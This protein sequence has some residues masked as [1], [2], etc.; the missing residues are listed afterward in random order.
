MPSGRYV[1]KGVN[2]VITPDTEIGDGTV[3]WHNVNLWGCRIGRN[4]TIGSYVEIGRGVVVGDNCK[5]EAFAY[6]PPGVRIGNGVFIGP[7]ATFTN[8]KYPAAGREWAISPTVVEDGAVIGA[9]A[10]VLPGITIGERA[11]V[12]AG[13]VVTKDVPGGVVV[14]GVPARPV[15][16]REDYERKRAELLARAGAGSP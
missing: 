13:A 16:T 14:A 3:I 6:I 15:G 5:I 1:V 11:V 9:G 10:I 7:R 8:D 12:A 4:C 2:V